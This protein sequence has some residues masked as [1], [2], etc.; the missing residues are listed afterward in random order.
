MASVRLVER[1]RH[2]N[3][4]NVYCKEDDVTEEMLR[5][6]TIE[7]SDDG[8][9]RLPR[10]TLLKMAKTVGA[11][12]NVQLFTVSVLPL[13]GSDFEV[14]L[15]HGTGEYSTVLALKAAITRA[16]GICRFRQTIFLLAADGTGGGPS[17]PLPEDYLLTGN[18]E[19]SLTVLT[20]PEFRW[21]SDDAEADNTVGE[22]F[23][24]SGEGDELATKIVDG[25]EDI[26]LH[27][28]PRLS[29]TS[30][31]PD[32]ITYACTLSLRLHL[33]GFDQSDAGL[34]IGIVDDEN[35]TWWDEDE[36]DAFFMYT[37][38]GCVYG[39]GDEVP[40][41]MVH[42][43][44]VLTMVWDPAQGSLRFFVDGKRHGR[45]L[46]SGVDGKS[47]R[48]AIT[49]PYSGIGCELV[50]TPALDS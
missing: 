48:W 19:V 4:G 34:R 13:G 8:I 46:P 7:I 49:I 22:I 47:M 45:G 33:G 3:R 38:D 21:R 10:A 12:T 32:A 2:L 15:E 39:H 16:R 27:L 24:L 37:H 42:D 44:Q 40:A 20:N 35:P 14:P 41:G 43:G 11:V 31:Q 30:H 17:R 9:L 26:V 18:C 28:W 6:I 25:R 50:D 5:I 29:A 36:D 23:R 1:L